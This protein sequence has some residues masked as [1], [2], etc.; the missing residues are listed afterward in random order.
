MDEYTL[1]SHYYL[2]LDALPEH[3][4]VF[5][6]QGQYLEVFGGQDNH[7]QFDCKAYVGQYL[8]D[9]MPLK[10][11]E[12]FLSYI[13]QAIKKNKTVIVN[14]HFNNDTMI[15]FPD[16]IE[17]PKELW[18]EGII[19][20]LAERYHDQKTVLWTARNI[21]Q[22][23]YLEKQLKALSETDELTGVL[24]RRAF[25]NALY[26]KR[27]QFLRDTQDVSLLMLDIDRFKSVNDSLGHQ[28]GD[29]VIKHVT[30]LCQQTIRQVDSLG[31][32]GGEEFAIILHDA[33]LDQAYQLASRL[34]QR[35]ATQPCIW[36][37]QPIKVTIS[38]G[39]STFKIEDKTPEQVIQRAD[40][41]MYTSKHLG[42]NLVSIFSPN[43]QGQF[44]KI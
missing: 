23:H 8:H 20:P 16:D 34:C 33:N 13:Q 32:L 38:I 5:S 2:L 28:A 24:N 9:V 15:R 40:H 12:L 29:A 17:P 14:Y 18:F 25:M 19:K 42:R 11:A 44:P 36:Q 26:N 7:T 4:F 10:S 22:R 35:V 27:Q 43:H 1:A 21:T 39:L 37:Q 30:E 3:V 6:E 41:A 31:R